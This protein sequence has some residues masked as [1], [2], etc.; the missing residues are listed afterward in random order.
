MVAIYPQQQVT[1]IRITISSI[2][3]S[4]SL[5]H[6]SRS[7]IVDSSDSFQRYKDRPAAKGANRVQHIMRTQHS[8]APNAIRP[9]Q[10]TSAW[11]STLFPWPVQ[12]EHPTDRWRSTSNTFYSAGRTGTDGLSLRL[13]LFTGADPSSS[14]LGLTSYLVPQGP[15]GVA[16]PMSPSTPQYGPE[17]SSIS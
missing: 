6:C 12:L 11:C 10:L 15:A 7:R 4:S 9:V 17:L 1:P 8:G 13:T 3:H 5:E 16:N 2:V 14:Y